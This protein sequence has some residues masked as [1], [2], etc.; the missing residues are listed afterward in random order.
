ML[1]RRS[2]CDGVLVGF[3]SVT[4]GA[5]VLEPWAAILT[6]IGGAV[7]YDV[8]CWALLKA[9]VSHARLIFA[10]CCNSL[11]LVCV[12]STTAALL[13]TAVAVVS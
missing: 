5:H 7:V 6:A 8:T 3:V 2:L 11:G 1:I 4:A 12:A 9:K 13:A 10:G